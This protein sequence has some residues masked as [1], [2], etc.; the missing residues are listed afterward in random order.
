MYSILSIDATFFQHYLRALS[1]KNANHLQT[2]D[3]IKRH[4]Q[5]SISYHCGWPSL[6]TWGSATHSGLP[7]LPEPLLRACGLHRVCMAS[8]KSKQQSHTC[9]PA[10]CTGS[11]AKSKQLL[12]ALSAKNANH[13]QTTDT[14]KRHRRYSIRHHCGWPSLWTWGSATHNGLPVLPEPLLRACG[15]HKVCTGFA[16]GPKKTKQQSRSIMFRVLGI[17]FYRLMQLIFFYIT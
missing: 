2:T 11:L 16:Q 1:A 6:W 7:A 5:Y 9:V 4:Q 15:L 8:K 10:V 12:R 3:T 14:I 13:L 17:Q